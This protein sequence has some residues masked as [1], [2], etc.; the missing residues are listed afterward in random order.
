MPGTCSKV[1]RVQVVCLMM[2]SAFEARMQISYA[3]FLIPCWPW[4]RLATLH[5]YILFDWVRNTSNTNHEF[6]WLRCIL[7]TSPTD[8]ANVCAACLLF[9]I[10]LVF[11]SMEQIKND[12]LS[13][14]KIKHLRKCKHFDW[15]VFTQN[16]PFIAFDKQW[17]S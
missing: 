14:I 5:M 17:S 3:A 13:P 6:A 1:T 16:I 12:V 10:A 8:T 9:T 7:L 2:N 11:K 15:S 4:N